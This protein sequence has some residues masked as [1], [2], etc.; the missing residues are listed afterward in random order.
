MGIRWTGEEIM[1]LLSWDK[2]KKAR[3]TEEHNDTFVADGAPPGTYV[4]N[5]SDE[6]Q[7]KWKAK[8]V[9]GKDLRVEIRKTVSGKPRGSDKWGPSASVLLV[10]RLD[11]TA[12]FSANGKAELNIVELIKVLEEAK[13]EMQLFDM[14]GKE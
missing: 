2:P 11:G 13:A 12:V 4:P 3:T 8:K 9:G 10:V 6:D 7:E 14:M 5:M 1:S